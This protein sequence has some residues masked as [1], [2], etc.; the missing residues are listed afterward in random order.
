[1][2]LTIISRPELNVNSFNSRWNAA[3]GNLPVKYGISNNLFP[4]ASTGSKTW[5]LDSNI[6]GYATL[7]NLTVP[8]GLVV[9]QWIYIASGAYAGISQVIRVTSVFSFT[10][11][12]AGQGTFGGTYFQYYNNYKINVNVFLDGVLTGTKAYTPTGFNSTVDISDLLKANLDQARVKEF[13][14]TCF[15]TYELIK[16]V[17]VN[18]STVS[19]AANVFYAVYASLPF[20][21]VFGGN[22]YEYV[23]GNNR[24]AKWMTDFEKPVYF[25]SAPEWSVSIISD[26]GVF[27]LTFAQFDQNGNL[28][29]SDVVNYSA[30]PGIFDIDFS[31]ITLDPDAATVEI[32]G[33]GVEDLT[34]EIDQYGTTCN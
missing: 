28:L 22:M 24:Q 26:S 8:H 7:I 19:D 20:A 2:A 31:G 6:G 27:D 4:F 34:V 21:N 25:P 13:Y 11:N 23:I 18:G 9:G 1:M 30:S 5:T 12:R 33:I 3:G 10:I 14:I 16:G 32:S 29:D 17:T 15:E